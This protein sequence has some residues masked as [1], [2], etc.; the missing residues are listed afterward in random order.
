MKLIPLTAAALAAITIFGFA[1]APEKEIT[2]SIILAA[3]P[4]EAYA[5]LIDGASYPA[6]NPFITSLEGRVGVGE[7]L[8]ITIEPSGGS[9]IVF[10]PEVLTAT[11]GVELRWLGSA[12][13]PGLFDGEH[14]FV[15]TTDNGE[16]VLTHGERFSGALL[17]FIDV[18]AFR[19][20][21]EHMNKALAARLAAG[22]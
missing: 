11:P 9:A 21:F 20:D 15:L 17:W 4:D 22:A 6:S 10:T 7:T 12:P 19:T 8:T 3:S 14:Y 2:T 18:E 16:T 13:L 5:A 1:L